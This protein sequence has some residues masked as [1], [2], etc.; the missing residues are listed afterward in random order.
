MCVCAR[1]REKERE[2]ERE[3]TRCVRTLCKRTHCRLPLTCTHTHTHIHKHKHTQTQTNTNTR[4]NLFHEESVIYF[5]GK[6]DTIASYTRIYIYIFLVNLF[7]R[8]QKRRNN[9]ISEHF[10]RDILETTVTFCHRFA[11]SNVIITRK[12][13]FLIGMRVRQ[14]SENTG[15]KLRVRIRA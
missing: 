14:Y 12:V 11:A 4:T 15:Y 13:Y 5:H 2:K 7:K 3:S 1:A 9:G 6:Q 8:I 10:I